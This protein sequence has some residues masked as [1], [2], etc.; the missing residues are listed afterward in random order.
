MA[1]QDQGGLHIIIGRIE[2]CCKFFRLVNRIVRQSNF[3]FGYRLKE[4]H[5]LR[6]ETVGLSE[7]NKSTD[8]P[9]LVIVVHRFEVECV[10][11]GSEGLRRELD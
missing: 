3:L 11:V 8:G 2:K 1:E 5:L 9:N 6:K 10:K 4:I 7:M